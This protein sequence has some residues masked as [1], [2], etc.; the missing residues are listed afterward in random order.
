[1]T[2]VIYNALLLAA[3]SPST[4]DQRDLK[5]PIIIGIIAV[6]LII[7]SVVMSVKS[8]KK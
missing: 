3:A 1:M 6:I 5:L 7:A 2:A 4:G 8:K